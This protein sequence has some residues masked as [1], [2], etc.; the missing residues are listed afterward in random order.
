MKWS[1][2]QL[3]IRALARDFAQGELRSAS[4]GWDAAKDLDA[5]IFR[6]LADLGFLGMLI[7]E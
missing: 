2:D 4:A 3:E 1:Q 7:P 6:K 5:G